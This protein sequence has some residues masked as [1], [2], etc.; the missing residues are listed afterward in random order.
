VLGQAQTGLGRGVQILLCAAPRYLQSP[1]YLG[2]TSVLLSEGHK[3]PLGVL[4]LLLLFL[5]L[6]LLLVRLWQ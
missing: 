3:Y 2:G 5:L 4:S 1:E 6:L